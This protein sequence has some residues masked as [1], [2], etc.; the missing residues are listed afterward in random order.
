MSDYE[1]AVRTGVCAATQRRLE[2]AEQFYAVLFETPE[3]FERRD[4]GLDSWEGPP[5]GFFSFWKSRVPETR[6][7][8]QLFIDGDALT[9]LFVRLGDC[10]E[11]VKKHFRFV[12]GLILMRKRLLKYQQTSHRGDS[13]Y[14]QMQIV[15]DQSMHEV[16]NPRMTDEQIEKVSREL[17]A[18]LH[19]DAGAFAKLHAE[20]AESE[21]ETKIGQA[22]EGAT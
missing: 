3:G 5:S 4:Y 19:G 16:L 2:P 7:K 8:K 20:G 12:L 22:G 13:E 15:R 18:I 17:G 1:V 9:H 14:W 11:E 21:P 10:R 6:E